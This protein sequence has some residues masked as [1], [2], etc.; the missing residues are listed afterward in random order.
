[1]MLILKL[2]AASKRVSGVPSEVTFLGFYYAVRIPYL[3]RCQ[4]GVTAADTESDA[5]SAAPKRLLSNFPLPRNIS[6][7]VRSSPVSYAW[8]N[9]PIGIPKE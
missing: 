6:A 2:N 4:T 8:R 5:R 3:R 9:F 1:M 7:F